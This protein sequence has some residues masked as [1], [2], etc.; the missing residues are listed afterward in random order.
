MPDPTHYVPTSTD[1]RASFAVGQA[2]SVGVRMTRYEAGRAFDRWLM[3]RLGEAWERGLNTGVGYAT[4]KRIIP[5]APE[6]ENPYRDEED[7]DHA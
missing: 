4:A 6:P 3:E 5:D 1:V 2:Q 7:E